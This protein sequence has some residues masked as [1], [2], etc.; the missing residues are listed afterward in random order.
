MERIDLTDE[1]FE[2]V[3]EGDSYLLTKGP[4]GKATLFVF[5]TP[6]REQMMLACRNTEAEMLSPANISSEVQEL[7]MRVFVNHQVVEVAFMDLSDLF[8]A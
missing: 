5:S 4:P 6:D 7:E 1:G 2:H 8:N 3:R